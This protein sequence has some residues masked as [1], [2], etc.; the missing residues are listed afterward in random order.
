VATAEAIMARDSMGDD[1][2]IAYS[3]FVV[4]AYF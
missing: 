3:N 2:G 4:N 1:G